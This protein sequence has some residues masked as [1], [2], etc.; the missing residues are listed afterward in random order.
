VARDNVRARA[1]YG[2]N[3]LVPDGASKLD[4][5]LEDLVEVRLVR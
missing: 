4:A 3:R 2:R 5:E 1:F